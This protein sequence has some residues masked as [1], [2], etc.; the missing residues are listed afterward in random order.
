[1]SDES[2]HT[3]VLAAAIQSLGDQP[4]SG[5]SFDFSSV[6]TSV[7][8]MAPVARLVENVGVSAYLGAAHLLDD[9][10][11]LTAAGSILTVEA[12]HQTILNVLN[13][14]TAIPQAFDIPFDPQEVLAIAGGFISGCDTGITALPSLTV[15][16]T[17]SIQAGTSLSFSFDALSSISD[18][19]VRTINLCGLLNV[20]TDMRSADIVVPDARGWHAVVALAPLR[21]VRRPYRFDRPRRHLR[22]EQHPAIGQ[23]PA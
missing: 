21:P 22:H 16:T 18:T 3:T 19:S 6:L 4:I 23:Q 15:T 13:G 1:M 10:V 17:G 2:T 9:P 14:G 12:R 5:C 20:F 7:S 8:A 11:L